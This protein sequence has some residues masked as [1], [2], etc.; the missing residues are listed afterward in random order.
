MLF[1]PN[2][3][4]QP[5]PQCYTKS[6][7]GNYVADAKIVMKDGAMEPS[8]SVQL[9]AMKT[10]ENGLK[11]SKYGSVPYFLMTRDGKPNPKSIQ[12]YSWSIYLPGYQNF[13]FETGERHETLN[14]MIMTG[15][16]MLIDSEITYDLNWAYVKSDDQEPSINQAFIKWL[17]DPAEGKMTLGLQEIGGANTAIYVFNKKTLQNGIT[18]AQTLFE[19]VKGTFQ[20][21][22]CKPV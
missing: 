9:Q 18:V 22:G 11:K 1:G 21:Q 14:V 17:G 20:K 8:F 5:L 4:A 7:K 6:E 19:G 3:W 13:E 12:G 10:V 15:G 2:A 16:E